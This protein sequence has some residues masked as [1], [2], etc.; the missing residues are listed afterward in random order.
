M[1]SVSGFLLTDTYVDYA[2]EIIYLYKRKQEIQKKLDKKEYHDID[3]Y[4]WLVDYSHK[5]EKLAEKAYEKIV[6]DYQ[7]YWQNCGDG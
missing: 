4:N 3:S 7:K 1:K 5:I 2:E 6:E